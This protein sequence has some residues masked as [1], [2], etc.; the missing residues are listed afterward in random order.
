[1]ILSDGTKAHNYSID[2]LSDL[3][4]IRTL[5]KDNFK[6]KNLI[7]TQYITIPHNP[8]LLDL[9]TRTIDNNY[10]ILVVEDEDVLKFPFIFKYKGRGIKS[11]NEYCSTHIKSSIIKTI[12][13]DGDGPL[14]DRISRA[15]YILYNYWFLKFDTFSQVSHNVC[16]DIES[17]ICIIINN[18]FTRYKDYTIT[19]EV[20]D[21]LRHKLSSEKL[22]S[23]EAI[24]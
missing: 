16:M 9:C 17:M 21:G 15:T 20:V 13:L 12:L 11:L 10:R 19:G 6:Y 1:M 4:L 8:E 24:Q 5:F 23:I 2:C 7:N 14:I 18:S 22:L 3:R